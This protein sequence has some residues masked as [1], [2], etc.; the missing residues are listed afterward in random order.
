MLSGI[1]KLFKFQ[2]IILSEFSWVKMLSLMDKRTI[3][4]TA[5]LLHVKRLDIFDSPC[6]NIISKRL[7]SVQLNKNFKTSNEHRVSKSFL[8]RSKFLK[9]YQKIELCFQNN[10]HNSSKFFKLILIEYFSC[11]NLL[12]LWSCFVT[13]YR[14]YVYL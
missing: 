12:Y 1:I 14:L 7:Y 13:M 8:K 9:L 4:I 11:R 3:F 6:R 2:K 5:G 10:K